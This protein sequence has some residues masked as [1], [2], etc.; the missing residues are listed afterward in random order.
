MGAVGILERIEQVHE[1][2]RPVQAIDRLVG[3]NCRYLLTAAASRF[4]AAVSMIWLRA[5]RNITAAG[6]VTIHRA[7]QRD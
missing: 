5:Q 2:C 4:L 1:L 6:S 3:E 7:K